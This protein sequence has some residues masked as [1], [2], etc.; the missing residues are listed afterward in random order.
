MS[1]LTLIVSA[2]F[3][4][5]ALNPALSQ[6][7]DGKTPKGIAY[8]YERIASGESVAVYFA[9]RYGSDYGAKDQNLVNYVV[10]ALTFGAGGESKDS[11]DQKLRELRAAFGAYSPLELT[12]GGFVTFERPK[13][14]Q[15]AALLAQI[16]QKPNY[17][18][19][20]LDDRY[21]KV[22]ITLRERFNREPLNQLQFV[23]FA[24][25][26]PD[27]A[28]R[29]RWAPVSEASVKPPPRQS[30]LDWHKRMLGRNNLVVSV[31]GNLSEGDAG[32][33]IDRVF[34]ALPAVTE[35]LPLPESTYR[36]LD[37]VIKIERN[38]PQVYVRLYGAVRR[39]EDPVKTIALQ[40]ALSAFGSGKESN[41]YKVLRE[42]LGAAY[43]TS[44]GTVAISPRL[45]LIAATV[46]ID[47]EK[48]AMAIDRL[49]DEYRK[50]L[51]KGIDEA[52]VKHE[53]DR[54]TT[55]NPQTV[56]APIRASANLLL[57]MRGLP[58]DTLNELRKT[59]R[60]IL[61]E[62]INEMIMENMPKAVTLVV[63]APAGVAIKADCTIKSYGDAPKCGF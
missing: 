19:K 15:V 59:Y 18:T 11:I 32:S 60:T 22:L 12:I 43:S 1:C 54:M 52:T 25:N 10:P 55:A 39:D 20:D 63:M 51:E 36:A 47:P 50:L 30:L 53:I 48:A 41:L 33:F 27:F 26:L 40:V 5:A 44:T 7:I 35:P 45:N 28:D 34:G 17:T 6:A 16:I 49:R 46:Q 21:K 62:Q 24:L 57:A 4:V 9:W 13:I 23:Q 31:A 42:E 2:I 14:D 38:V 58:V 3:V 61:T 29:S 37:K 8:R 56:Q